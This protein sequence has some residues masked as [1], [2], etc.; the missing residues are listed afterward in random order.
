MKAGRPLKFKTAKDLEDAAL[1]YFAACGVDMKPLT[2][3]GLA[4]AL[5]TTRQTLLEYEGE[6][7]GR[8]KKDPEFA[9]TVKRL[10]TIVENYA[11]QALFG[12]NATGPIFALKN[13]GWSDRHEITDPD[14]NPIVPMTVNVLNAS[15]D[16]LLK[17]L[18]AQ[19]A[20]SARGRRGSSKASSRN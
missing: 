19:S 18:T 9:D 15:K 2:I 20:N 14:G 5:G 17:L 4:L 1:A 8:E 10:K 16:D 11:E 6:V 3:T 12:K 13:F 7:Q